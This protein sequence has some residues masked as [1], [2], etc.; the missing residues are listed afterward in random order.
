MDFKKITRAVLPFALVAVMQ[1][2]AYWGNQWYAETFGNPG[3]D[4]SVI[5]L[6]LN[7]AVPFLPWTVWPYVIAYPFWILG[8]FYIGSRDKTNMYRILLMI[9]VTFTICGLWYLFFQTDVQAWRETS[10]LFARDPSTFTLSESLT[11]WIYAAAGPRNANPSMHC[12]MSWLVILGARLDKKMPKP[13]K[14]AIW[15]LGIAICI[16][17]QTLKQHYVIDLIT[18]IALPEA[19]FWLLKGSKAVGWLER[20]FTKLNV[21]L[22]LESL[23]AAE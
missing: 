11:Y 14:I 19:A 21:K 17:T 6:G 5:F 20:T 15:V 23:P 16:S 7:E 12:L 10:G 2:A 22:G 1:F 18:G 13:A 3:S 9:L 8:F 4:L